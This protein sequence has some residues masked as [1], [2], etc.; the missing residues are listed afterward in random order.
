MFS[1]KTQLQSRVMDTCP[2]YRYFILI[3]IPLIVVMFLQSLHAGTDPMIKVS[4]E[5]SHLNSAS[6]CIGDAENEA[7]MVDPVITVR[8]S[9]PRY[10]CDTSRY[11][12]DVEFQSNTANKEIF[13]MNVRFWYD[14]NLLEFVRFQNFPSSYGAVAPSPPS[15]TS[16]NVG[17]S[18]FGFPTIVADYVNGA[19]QKTSTNATPI[20]ISTNGWTKLFSIVFHVD[21]PNADYS[22]FY[23]AVIG[24]LELVPSNGGFLPGNDGIVI[25]LVNPSGGS[26]P[27]TE[28]TIPLNWV[29]TGSGAPP[30]GHPMNTTMA[31]FY[32][33]APP[34]TCPASVT[35]SCGDSTLPAV[36]GTATSADYCIAGTPV[37]T[38]SDVQTGGVC[39]QS[40]L[41]TRIWSAADSCGN[42]SYCQQ[43][44]TVGTGSSCNLLV[45][46]D[47]D[48][49]TGSLRDA[50]NCAL[51][52]D[53]ITFHA[54]LA[55]TTI[56]ITSTKIL[57][58]KNLYIRSNITPRIKIKSNLPGLFDIAANKTIEFKD[59]DIISGI[60]TTGNDGAAFNNLG[61][62]KLI[63]VKVYRNTLLP[64]GQY[65]IRNKPASQFTLSGSCFIQYN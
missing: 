6:P 55:N 25:T 50:I 21:D 43:Y 52:G 49:G 64:T 29:Y 11:I 46:N 14:D 60:A 32:N 8:F 65:L 31:P 36:L 38:Y 41:I 51:S 40:N 59:L 16:V 34:I 54:S 20:Y 10:Y 62:L 53:T 26:L 18:W 63:G 35:I 61:T 23:A 44:I 42:H 15:V 17:T 33:C 28:N 24:D 7:M 39:P 19:M 22:N 4:G 47:N 48:A 56:L 45:T 27:S 37:I 5:L 2:L 9:N 3:V 58:S 13:G 30:Y 1:P 57:L 12:V